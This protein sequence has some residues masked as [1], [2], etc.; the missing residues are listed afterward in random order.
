MVREPQRDTV[1]RGGADLWD[2]PQAS[3]VLSDDYFAKPEPEPPS[4]D[5]PGMVMAMRRRRRA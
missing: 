2:Q 1:V 3:V 4:E 5:A